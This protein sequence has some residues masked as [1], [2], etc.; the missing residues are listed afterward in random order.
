MG[1]FTALIY[2]FSTLKLFDCLR[3]CLCGSF[4]QITK[5][6]LEPFFV[7][8]THFLLY[9]FITIICL[10][11]LIFHWCRGEANLKELKSYYIDTFF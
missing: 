6:I 1:L 5:T 9:F 10:M 2:Y 8:S 11:S 4:V 7:V 3:F